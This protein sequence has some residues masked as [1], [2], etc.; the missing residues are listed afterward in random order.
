M[1]SKLLFLSLLLRIL[2]IAAQDIDLYGVATLHN[3]KYKTGKT[4][5][6]K[7]VELRAD[8]ASPTASDDRGIFRLLFRGIPSGTSVDVIAEKYG[9]EV[10]NDRDL[11]NVVLGRKDS[12]RIFFAPKGELA[13]AQVKLYNINLRRITQ[14]YEQD[15]KRLKSNQKQMLGALENRFNKKIRDRM[16]A[17]ELLTQ[18]FESI[19]QRLPEITRQLARENLDYAPDYYRRV[20]ERFERAELD[21]ALLILESEELNAS[22]DIEA[23]KVLQSDA[24]DIDAAIRDRRQAIKY[25]LNGIQF[26]VDIHVLKFNFT[27]AIGIYR[28]K[29][30]YLEEVREYWGELKLARAYWIFS[31][32]LADDGTF[33]QALEFIN[34]AIEIQERLL[35]PEDPELGVSY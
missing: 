4:E 23:L 2:T 6:V 8:F 22:E 20:I 35:R 24:R 33:S 30:Q 25:K 27:E 12:L 15:I 3:S 14:Q 31:R 19:K 7:N 13:K 9:L 28:E 11:K 1:K 17:E 26:K 18:K 32:L 34:K 5:F 29:I 21:S 10:V 16:E